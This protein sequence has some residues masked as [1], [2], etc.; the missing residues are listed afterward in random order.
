MRLEYI[1]ALRVFAEL[2]LK[3]LSTYVANKPFV[4]KSGGTLNTQQWVRLKELRNMQES[5]IE[6]LHEHDNSD[7]VFTEA[8]HVLATEMYGSEEINIDSL[9]Y[10]FDISVSEDG[11]DISGGN[12]VTAWVWLPA[13]EIKLAV[14]KERT[15]NSKTK[16]SLTE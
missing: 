6:S 14:Q 4:L 16:K 2:D 12:W 7:P 15:E 1:E 9:R 10:P 8:L 13:E 3:L 11:L 5:I